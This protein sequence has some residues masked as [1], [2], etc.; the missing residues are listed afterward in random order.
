MHV[1]ITVKTLRLFIAVVEVNCASI[2]HVRLC[3]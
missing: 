1:Q 3:L 2:G